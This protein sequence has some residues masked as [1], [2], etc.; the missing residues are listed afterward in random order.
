MSE[1]TKP[2]AGTVGRPSG[3]DPAGGQ[4]TA[5]DRRQ[6]LAEF[7][8]G[9]T[10]RRTPAEAGLPTFGRRRTPGLRRE[11]VATL[12]GVSVT[13]YTWL[14]QARR[15]RVSRQ[16][17]GSLAGALGL[18]DIERA[19]LFRLA[20]E[21]PPDRAPSATELPSQYQVL[22]A[23]LDPN[24]AFV[25]NPRFD[26]LA[27]NRGCELLYGDL[28]ALPKERRN[29]LWLTFT[30]PEVREMVRDWE[31]EA[32]LTV[33]LFRTQA[34]DAVLAPGITG[35]VAELAAASPDFARLWERKD[36]APFV[37]QARTIDHP[38]LGE[39]TLDYVK[40]HLSNDDKTLVS[41]LL[42]PGSELESRFTKLV[43][44]PGA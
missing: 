18:D 6:E 42:P 12:A 31:A 8:R 23:H 9:P 21:P 10:A 35:L 40:L 41:Y 30:A 3:P 16:I 17:L 29:V 37:P 28:G 19:H 44:D 24:P 33:A 11:E 1:Q 43:G 4:V 22:L 38:L 7:L 34:S 5:Q 13:W 39:V 15:I 25:V 20:D 2:Q 26:I 36:L 27:W 14:E 32:A